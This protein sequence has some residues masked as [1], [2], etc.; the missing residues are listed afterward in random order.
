MGAPSEEG[1]PSR[2]WIP[3]EE[4]VERSGVSQRSLQDWVR[5]GKIKKE[6]QNGVTYLWVSDLVQLTPLQDSGAGGARTA[7]PEIVLQPEETRSSSP[8]GF[9]GLSR[10]IAEEVREGLAVQRQI[11]E[12]VQRLST[13]AE[14]DREGR[15]DEKTAKELALLGNVFRAVHQ[16][17]EKVSLGLAAQEQLLKDVLAMNRREDELLHRAEREREWHGRALAGLLLLLLALVAGFGALYYHLDG[18]KAAA[19]ARLRTET[20]ETRAALDGLRREKEAELEKTRAELAAAHREQAEAAER[21]RVERAG[22]QAL[23]LQEAEELRRG[24]E[25][26]EL[27]KTRL[28]PLLENLPPGNPGTE[29]AAPAPP[30]EP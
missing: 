1:R 9:V 13:Q 8:A 24:R 5:T 27:L 18:E 14:H 21:A 25:M 28:L 29:P 22:L 19:E 7:P 3:L 30:S 2:L 26:E 20:L 4:A 12:S 17:N 23:R 6:R 11:L 15:L 10:Q 16:Q